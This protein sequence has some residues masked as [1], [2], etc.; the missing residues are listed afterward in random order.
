[1][2]ERPFGCFAQL[3]PDPLASPKSSRNKAL[4]PQALGCHRYDVE[5]SRL[6]NLRFELL[7]LRTKPAAARR[8]LV[9]KK[10]LRCLFKP[11]F[12]SRGL[13]GPWALVL[14][15]ARSCR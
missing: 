14:F 4:A 11:L 7:S 15:L 6:Q 8:G 12:A 9:A 3:T 13:Q 2:P 5:I 1:L 10:N